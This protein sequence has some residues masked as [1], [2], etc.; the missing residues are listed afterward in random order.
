MRFLNKTFWR[1]VTG[2]VSIVVI[3]LLILLFVN[4]FVE[5]GA[6]LEN[7]AVVPQAEQ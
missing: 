4:L 7:R 2:F 5:D 1:F 6:N 3:A